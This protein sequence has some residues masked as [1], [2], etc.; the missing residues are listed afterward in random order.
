MAEIQGEHVAP[1]AAADPV[2]A[3]TAPKVGEGL[4]L[5]Q[6]LAR[7]GPSSAAHIA[8]TIESHPN[9]RDAIMTWLHQ[10]GGAQLVQAVVAAARAATSAKETPSGN[11]AHVGDGID[12]D[13]LGSNGRAYTPN[14][15]TQDIPAFEPANG[16]PK[17]EA[18]YV[19]GILVDPEREAGTGAKGPKVTEAQMVA[20]A[21]DVSV[22][23]VH[24]ASKGVFLDSLETITDKINMSS[25]PAVRT[26]ADSMTAHVKSG[27]QMTYV[28]H[29]QG[30][31]QICRALGIT[32]GA[33]KQAGGTQAEIQAHLGVL[34]I[35]TLAGATSHWPDGPRYDHYVNTKDSVP[36]L[37]GVSA[38]FA[39]GGAGANYHT[40]T[41]SSTRKGE[42]GLPAGVANPLH[43]MTDSVDRSTHGLSIYID[44]ITGSPIQQ[45][46]G[47]HP[48]TITNSTR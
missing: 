31:S 47:T 6:S 27:Q 16:K 5:V 28:G 24:N 37:L 17:G 21:F 4:A 19:N 40:F 11:Q 46:D 44:A 26:I 8:A 9:E 14:T 12:G 32:I 34:H 15:P 23:P 18:M 38:L 29:S 7:R 42:D 10:N 33:M 2:A 13:I 43:S 3:S 35:I 48:V 20:D 25:E 39:N 1:T 36:R 30:A 41:V 45:A 22:Y